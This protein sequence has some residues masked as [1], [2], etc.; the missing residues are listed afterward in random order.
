LTLFAQPGNFS[1]RSP[2]QQEPKLSIH[3]R[4]L[5][6][7]AG[8]AVSVRDVQKQIELMF[9]ERFPEFRNSAEARFQFYQ[10]NW[11]A[12][13]NAVLD[14]ELMLADARK[15]QMPVSKT[16][17]KDEM[18]RTFGPKVLVTLANLGMT[19]SEA[20]EAMEEEILIRRAQYLR[21]KIPAQESITP[22]RLKEAYQDY[23]AYFDAEAT[24]TYRIA[25]FRN[26]NSEALEALGQKAYEK[27]CA[28]KCS[29]D[30]LSEVL[31]RDLSD[32]DGPRCSV[33]SPY[34]QKESSISDAYLE[35]LAG[36]Q[37]MQFSAPISQ[38]N[39]R[40]GQ[41]VVRIF[42]LIGK[43]EALPETFASIVPQL[44][45]RLMTEALAEQGQKYSLRLRE[46]F[47]V[48]EELNQ[49]PKDFQPFSLT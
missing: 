31:A 14:R 27:L 19:Y 38:V 21:V 10:V 23:L 47:E 46:E 11:E 1:A 41:T 32:Q 34:Q 35:G 43:E 2:L 33:S 44:E 17:I 22:G 6:N 28:G 39:R 49:L 42:Q 25:S 8:K 9:M 5:A 40:D 26:G 45:S 24:W 37:G 4:I 3:N 36:I 18:E 20:E 16:D 29:F 7:I 12:A 48:G 15:M 13:L 30:G